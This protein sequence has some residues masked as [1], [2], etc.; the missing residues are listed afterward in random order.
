MAMKILQRAFEIINTLT[1]RNPIQVLV[2]AIVN[3]GPRED[4]NRVGSSGVARRQ[5]VD[6]SPLRRV[7][8]SIAY[9]TTAV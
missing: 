9:I 8:L 5:A 4:S 3:A 1:G 6:V 7:N 2:E